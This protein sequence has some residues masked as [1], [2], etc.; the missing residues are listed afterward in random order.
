MEALKNTSLKG[1]PLLSASLKN[2][3]GL[4]PR[5]KYKARSAHS[6]GQLHRPSVPQVL[7]DVYGTIGLLFDGGVVDCDLKFVSNDW[8]PDRVDAV[9]VGKVI[10][11]ESLLA[12]DR[13]ACEV[14]GEPAAEYLGKIGEIFN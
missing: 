6:R 10:F 5:A 9:L 7:Q 4:F 13:R 12:V 14:G 8:R 1:S 11:G 3:Y 2:L